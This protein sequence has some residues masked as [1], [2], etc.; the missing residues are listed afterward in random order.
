[1]FKNI[2]KTFAI[3][4]IGTAAV[5]SVFAFGEAKAQEVKFGDDVTVACMANGVV[6][7]RMPV[8][9]ERPKGNVFGKCPIKFE[10]GSLVKAAT[11]GKSS[12]HVK[13]YKGKTCTAVPYKIEVQEGR[14]VLA[15][16]PWLKVS[17]RGI[18]PEG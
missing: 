12:G 10:M 4:A 8:T 14:T 13:A 11:S 18:F 16:Y 1:M 9:F 7:D 3:F 6:V 5:F 15:T 2:A 17:C